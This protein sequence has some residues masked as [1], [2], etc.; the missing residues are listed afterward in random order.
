M[1]QRQYWLD[2][3]TAKT[4]D[5]FLA[6]GATVSGF[7]LGRRGF[8]NHI[9]PGDYLLCYLVGISRFVGVLEVTSDPFE[10]SEPIWS[11]EAF[12]LRVRVK[13]LHRLEPGTGVPIKDLLPRFSWWDPDRPRF[14]E[15]KVQGSPNQ[16]ADADGEMVTE[17]IAEAVRSPLCVPSTLD[18]CVARLRREPIRSQ[19]PPAPSRVRRLRNSQSKGRVASRRDGAIVDGRRGRARDAAAGAPPLTDGVPAAEVGQRDASTT[20]GRPER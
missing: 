3:F 5:E 11:A 19:A 2:L 10:D 14:W 6:A 1:S 8:V 16:W 13:L 9:K 18:A 12:P 7:R 4:W 20:L 15:G 17:A